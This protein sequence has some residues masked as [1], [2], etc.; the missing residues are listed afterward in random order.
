VDG[1]V[2]GIGGGG[3]NVLAHLARAIGTGRSVAV[4]RSPR[5]P[6]RGL[7]RWPAPSVSNFSVAVATP[8]VWPH[9]WSRVHKRVLASESS[10]RSGPMGGVSKRS[11][12]FAPTPPRHRAARHFDPPRFR[13][14]ALW[15]Q[16]SAPSG[17]VASAKLAYVGDPPARV[18]PDR[19]VL[20]RHVEA[21]SVATFRSGAFPSAALA[22]FF[23]PSWRIGELSRPAS[24]AAPRA[25]QPYWRYRGR[26][27]TVTRAKDSNV[28][29]RGCRPIVA[30]HPSPER[31]T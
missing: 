16:L 15:R 3:R 27:Q 11:S 26:A 30:A 14:R 6:A 8:P 28:C 22:S 12:S 17:A 9:R 29:C 2:E 18:G 10:Q 4:P 23:W 31:G 19:R 21:A 20:V 7:L 24:E 13:P 5:L 25:K 1:C